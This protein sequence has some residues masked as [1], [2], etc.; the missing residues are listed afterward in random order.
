MSVMG[1][2]KKS[3]IGGGGGA[4]SSSQFCFGLWEYFLCKAHLQCKETK[5]FSLSFMLWHVAMYI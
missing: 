4:M 3:F 1:Y 5:K 2:Q